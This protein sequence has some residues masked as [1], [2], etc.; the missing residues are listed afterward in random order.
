MSA[1]VIVHCLTQA[2]EFK[3]GD[4]PRPRQVWLKPARR[5]L[6]QKFRVRSNEV[7]IITLFFYVLVVVVWRVDFT[8]NYNYQESKRAA[9]EI[10]CQNSPTIIVS[11]KTKQTP[12][13]D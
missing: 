6:D 9:I 7:I 4:Q 12:N 8:V 11:A 5:P 10:T 13:D 3:I 1:R 2:K